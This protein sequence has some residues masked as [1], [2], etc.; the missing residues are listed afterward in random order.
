MGCSGSKD[1]PK[2]SA[3][4]SAAPRQQPPAPHQQPVSAVKKVENTPV[5]P[6]SSL[7]T[8]T[9]PSTVNASAT[10]A[11]IP[12]T[13]LSV[14]VV[15]S[16]QSEE[17]AQNETPRNDSQRIGRTGEDERGAATDLAASPPR[18]VVEDDVDVADLS[19]TPSMRTLQGAQLWNAAANKYPESAK[20]LY[21]AAMSLEANERLHLAR[22]PKGLDKTQAL[23]ESIRLHNELAAPYIALG[24][25]LKSKDETITLADGTV[26]TRQQCYARAV[27]HAPGNAIAW[28]SLGNTIG[29]E[30]TISVAGKDSVGKLDCFGQA[31][32]L[33]SN[34]VAPLRVALHYVT[35]C[36][37]VTLP[38]KSRLN[39]KELLIRLAT[40]EPSAKVFFTLADSISLAET[41]DL[42]DANSTT[43]ATVSK[44]D[45]LI[46]AVEL[47][48]SYAPAYHALMPLL[49]NDELIPL[50]TVSMHVTSSEPR[51]V[52]KR[53]CCIKIIEL[54][55][56]NPGVAYATLSGL[57]EPKDDEVKLADGRRLTQRSASLAA[58][59]AQPWARD[60]QRTQAA[61]E[62]GDDD[63]EFDR[64]NSSDEGDEA[65]LVEPYE[66]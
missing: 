14:V 43:A 42:P 10:A 11:T 19:Y 47:D 28:Y 62:A 34:F 51:F 40:V 22:F 9:E 39:K 58:V 31:I 60:K 4:S 44:R 6:P 66:A 36:R 49:T 13:S 30:E 54:D 2:P 56:E 12:A 32:F 26:V 35:H 50:R 46:R 65:V 48:D 33:D 61:G 5:V 29:L 63:G 38:N 20:A 53:H 15:P 8:S 59:K 25:G 37:S 57:M 7:P 23:I 55:R 16:A 3:A 24:N 21:K 18:P 1:G 41:V 17:L 52:S 27:S 64:S 45:L